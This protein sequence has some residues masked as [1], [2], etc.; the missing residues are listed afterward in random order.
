MDIL[1]VKHGYHTLHLY[2]GVVVKAWFY[3]QLDCYV[4]IDC[5][6]IDF[7]EIDYIE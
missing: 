3:S 1:G 2:N 4:D 5:D 7:D 6:F